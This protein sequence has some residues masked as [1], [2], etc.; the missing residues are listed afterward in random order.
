MDNYLRELQ[1]LVHVRG[2]RRRRLLTECR[3]HLQDACAQY[4]SKE[5]V[6]RFGTA[7]EIAASLNTE[8]AARRA[9]GATVA[10]VLGVLTAGGSTLALLHASET[11]ATA[12]VGWAI[13]FFAAAQVA[14]VCTALAVLQATAQRRQLTTAQDVA[15]LCRRNSYALLAAGITMFAAGAAVP[16][17]GSAVLLLPGPALAAAAGLRV[18]STRTIIRGLPAKR[19]PLVHSPLKDLGTLTG[20]TLPDQQGTKLL[21]A[22]IVVASAAAFVWDHQDQGTV[23]S[24]LTTASIQATLVLLGFLLLGPALGLRPRRHRT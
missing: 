8:I 13:V 5:A 19:G 20:L 22:T 4:G 7:Q 17:H 6:R 11:G 2:P 23:T 24:A 14:A 16:G 18:A 15:L 12:P 10:T 9:Q 1:R 21:A 3:H